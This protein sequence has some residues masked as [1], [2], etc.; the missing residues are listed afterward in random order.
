MIIDLDS[1]AGAIGVIVEIELWADSVLVV[2]CPARQGLC[3]EAPEPQG[4][5]RDADLAETLRVADQ[6]L[7][8]LE[9]A[10]FRGTLHCGITEDTVFVAERTEDLSAHLLDLGVAASEGRSTHD[11]ISALATLL[12][13]MSDRPLPQPFGRLIERALGPRTTGWSSAGE[14]RSA[15][16]NALT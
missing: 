6:L 5:Q 12:V 10:H 3:I 14:L 8:A 4:V 11:D 16:R 1:R 13:Q 2:A 9:S 7:S 15:L